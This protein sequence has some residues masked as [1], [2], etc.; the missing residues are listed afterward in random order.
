[1]Y[2]L[3]YTVFFLLAALALAVIKLIGV[4]DPGWRWLCLSFAGVTFLGVGLILLILWLWE[5]RHL[6]AAEKGKWLG[7][8]LGHPTAW[9][10][11]QG[12]R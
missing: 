10:R 2:A 12:N 4:I 5:R 7:S 9:K 3:V 8:L 1:M 11:R 6:T